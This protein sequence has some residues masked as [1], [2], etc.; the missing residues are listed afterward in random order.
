V[1]WFLGGAPVDALVPKAA[2]AL[3][4]I[5]P[6]TATDR[7]R[8][9]LAKDLVADIKRYDT[10]LAANS[11]QMYLILDEHVSKSG[12]PTHSGNGA[13][14]NGTAPLPARS[15]G[16]QSNPDGGST[17]ATGS[18]RFSSRRQ[19]DRPRGFGSDVS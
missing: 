2:G 4:S 17:K 3:R 5:R 11:H 10:Q 14:H 7:V 18:Q 9:E 13:R 12:G 1:S 6:L 15:D 19:A 16:R 8:K